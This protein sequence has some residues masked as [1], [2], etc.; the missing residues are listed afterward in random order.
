MTGWRHVGEEV[1]EAAGITLPVEPLLPERAPP[2]ELVPP[3]T[4]RLDVGSGLPPAASDA[5]KQV[6]TSLHLA[7]L[8]QCATWVWTDGSTTGGVLNGGTGVLIERPDG[9]IDEIRTPAGHL[10]SSFRAEMTA[11]QAALRYLLENP[12]H[13]EDPVVVCTDS[14]SALATLRGGPAAQSAPLGVS[15]WRALRDLTADGRQIHLQWVP[16]HCGLRGNERADAIARDA[17]ALDQLEVAVDVRTAHRAAARLAR[18]KTIAAWPPGWY[19]TLMGQ[20]LPP[21]VAGEDRSAAVDIHQ[22]RAGHWSGSTQWRHR[23]G[24]SPSRHCDQCK[25]QRCNAALCAVC[26]EEADT[27]KHVLLMGKRHRLLG[28]IQ[29]SPEDVRSS[30]VVAALG[31][32]HRALQS[33]T[34]TPR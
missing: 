20:R 24:L 8:P 34:A 23:V 30:D 31:A 14:Q 28:S 18:A 25:D 12:A 17:S 2:W 9:E 3:V 32:A 29:P 5:Q 21:P 4:F 10:C 1:W 26:R 22:L 33:L 7:A 6:V 11:L 27:P 16:A 15:I 13:E 19:R